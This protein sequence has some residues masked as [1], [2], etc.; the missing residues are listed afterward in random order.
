MGKNKKNQV[1]MNDPE[2]LKNAGNNS[3]TNGKM[4]EAI[5][6]YSKAIELNGNND[7]Y[8]ANSK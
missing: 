8:Y 6:Y 7:V 5:D 2:S 4:E 3:Y 1:D